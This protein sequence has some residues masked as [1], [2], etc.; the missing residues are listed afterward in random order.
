MAVA[1]R[2]F[3][4]R[5]TGEQVYQ[6]LHSQIVRGELRPGDGL[7]ETRVGERYGLSRTPVREVFWRLGEEGLLRVVPQVGTFVAPINIPAVYDSQ[8]I[9]ETLECRTVAD[10]ARKAD[11]SDIVAL[12]RLLDE[13]AAAIAA[14][15][16]VLF[17]ARDE[18][19]HRLLMEVAG[20]PFVWPVIASAKAQLDRVRFLSLADKNWLEMIL[21][22][23]RR[24]VGLVA[25]HDA[26]GAVGVMTTHLRTA[27]A[28][29]GRI[30]ADHPDFFEGS[31]PQS[32]LPAART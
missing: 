32:D 10:A 28:A 29:I 9:R 12:R 2:K 19:M 16:F 22:Q 23:H 11:K 7:T 1:P 5:A 30:A 31:L 6:D 24:I 25:A 20:H 15:D 27:F 14:G 13:Q 26:E 3:A 17:F 8:F 18:Q 21:A 4:P